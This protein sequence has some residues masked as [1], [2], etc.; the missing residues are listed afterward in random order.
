[1]FVH[2][3]IRKYKS[4]H[5]R[6]LILT[7]SSAQVRGHADNA[8]AWQLWNDGTLALAKREN[9]LIFLSIGYAACHCNASS[10][11]EQGEKDL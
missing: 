6:T 1:M 4:T 5:S 11:L 8:T 2:T 9:K 10:L 3:S 7:L